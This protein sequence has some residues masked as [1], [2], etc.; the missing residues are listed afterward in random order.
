MS[1]KSVPSYGED[2]LSDIS[3]YISLTSDPSR[4]ALSPIFDIMSRKGFEDIFL[5]AYFEGG[6]T[7]AYAVLLGTIFASRGWRRLLPV[8]KKVK[9][10]IYYQLVYHREWLTDVISGFLIENPVKLKPPNGSTIFL[11]D[12]KLIVNGIDHPICKRII[13]NK[14]KVVAQFVVDW[15]KMCP[16]ISKNHPT[17]FESFLMFIQ[18]GAIVLHDAE[19]GEEQSRWV[20]FLSGTPLMGPMIEPAH[21][22]DREYNDYPQFLVHLQNPEI[23]L[24]DIANVIHTS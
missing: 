7:H 4:R 17:I 11:T 2:M 20:N 9:T 5:A 15:S 6:I 23:R 21:M 3:R 8:N 24:I 13:N 18:D 12:H 1:L 10:I 19:Y 14:K 22:C 16:F